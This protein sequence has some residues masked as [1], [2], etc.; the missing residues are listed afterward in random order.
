MKTNYKKTFLGGIIAFI[1]GTS[2]CWLTSLAVWLGGVT[3]LTVFA[4]FI[5]KFNTTIIIFSIFLFGLGMFQL[6]IHKRK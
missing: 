5:G 3:I 1:L 2:C 6:W 4:T